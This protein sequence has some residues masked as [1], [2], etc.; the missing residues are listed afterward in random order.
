MPHSLTAV[1]P[2]AGLL[3]LPL[4]VGSLFYRLGRPRV[5]LRAAAGAFAKGLVLTLL[6]LSPFAFW[7]GWC[8]TKSRG[9]VATADSF[10]VFSFGLGPKVNDRPTAGASNR[11][12]A[13]WLVEN[14]PG[15]KPAV[16]QEGVYLAL[17]ELTEKEPNLLERWD[18]IRLPERDGFYVDTLAAAYQADSLLARNGLTRPVLVSHDLQL[19]RTVQTFAGI[20]VTNVVVPEMPP[21]PFDPDSVQHWGTRY[22]PVWLL[23]EAFAARPLTLAPHTTAVL[24]AF[25]ALVYGIAIGRVWPR[26]GA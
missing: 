13:E 21:V 4:A 9:D 17:Q 1:L 2:L 8:R 25:A 22:K 18:V 10:V 11:A 23:R 7:D 6:V 14:N 5:G 15:K 26:R 16:V 20:G 24:L 3:L 19:C 12:L